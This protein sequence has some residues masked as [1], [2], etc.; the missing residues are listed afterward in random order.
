MKELTKG[1]YIEDLQ[2]GN[3]FVATCWNLTVEEVVKIVDDIDQCDLTIIFEYDSV[4][5]RFTDF[6]FKLN[7]NDKVY[8]EFTNYDKYYTHKQI[9]YHV[10]G[11][12]IHINK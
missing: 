7:N 1:E 11:N 6:E 10:S 4:K 2:A 5:E 8:R 12:Q 3:K 9:L